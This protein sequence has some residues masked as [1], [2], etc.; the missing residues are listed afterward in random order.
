MRMI[1]VGGHLLCCSPTNNYMGHGFYQFSPELYYR[2]LSPENGFQVVRMFAHEGN[3]SDTWYDIP[4][5]E[6]LNRRVE[7][8]NSA[9][10]LLLILAT[11]IDETPIFSKTPLQSD[12]VRVW[13]NVQNSKRP[14]G[15]QSGGSVLRR[16]MPAS[17]KSWIKE[18]VTT[19]KIHENCESVDPRRAGLFSKMK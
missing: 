16:M 7:L 2:M 18:A 8:N 10:T 19:S 3:E 12:Y 9:R 15:R 13:K 11:R 14:G 1:E 5:P 6:L 17:I 4:D